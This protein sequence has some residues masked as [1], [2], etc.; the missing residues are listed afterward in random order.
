M[1]EEK[2]PYTMKLKAAAEKSGLSEREI[3]GLIQRGKVEGSKPGKEFLVFWQS[4][5]DHIARNK[6]KPKAS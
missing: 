3:K 2:K 5:V 4:L 6:I 1:S